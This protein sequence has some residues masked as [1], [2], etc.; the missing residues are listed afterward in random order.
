MA[1]RAWRR[2]LTGAEQARLRSFYHRSRTENAL[3]HDGAIRAV[4]ARVLVSPAFLYRVEP[5]PGHAE[6]PLNGSEMASRLSFFLWS[7]IPD[8]ELRRAAAA[9]E[10][11]RP[12][13][14]AQQVRR[15][16]ADPRARR[17]ATEFFGQWLGFYRFD[18]YRGVDTGRFP[19][20]TS[21]VQLAMYDEAVS[22][23]EYLVRRGRPL[24]EMLQADYTFL[25]RPLATFCRIYRGVKS[26]RAVGGVGGDKAEGRWD[27]G[28]QGSASR[29]IPG[30]L[31]R[32]RDASPR[33]AAAF[34][35]LDSR[36]RYAMVHHV[37]TAKRPETRARNAAKFVEMLERGERL[38]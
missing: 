9:G 26:G 28:D 23:F 22:T 3:D 25:T 2:P 8:D 20:F 30:G 15:M 35:G 31:G 6:R 17:L 4:L 37:Q 1:S 29:D 16:T 21:E 18:Q 27:A 11:S 24:K 12:A 14:L 34:A 19:E 13:T 10:L 5:E 7:S 33:A 38:Y 32:A 36:N